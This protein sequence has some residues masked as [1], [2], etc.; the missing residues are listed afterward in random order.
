MMDGEQERDL[1]SARAWIAS[2]QDFF[3]ARRPVLIARAPGRLDVMGGIADYS[4]SLVL[5]LPLA[6]ATW[7]AVQTQERAELVIESAG[8][9]GGRVTLPLEEIVPAPPLSYAEARARLT[10]DPVA[11]WTAY[12]A[13]AL[14]VMQREYDRPLR[15]GARVL[16]RSD[17]PIGKGVGSSAA[18]EVAAFEALAALAGATLDD[19]ALALAAQRVENLIVGA[20]CGVMDQVTAACGRRGELTRIF[21]QPAHLMPPLDVPQGLELYGIDSGIRHAVSGSDYGSV[22]AAAFMGYRIVADAAGLTARVIAPGRVA[23]DDVP[24]FGGYLVNVWIG[25]WR[26]RYR[27][28]V[29]ERMTGREFLARF[30]GSTDTATT[31]EEDRTYPV[32]AAAEFPIL[33]ND[34]ARVFASRL[35]PS[36]SRGWVRET[37]GDLM[38]QSHAGYSACGLGSDGTDHLVELCRAAGPAAGIYGAKITG[39]GSGGTVAVLAKAGSRPAIEEIARA[40]RQESGRD[41]QIFAGSSSGSR[42]FGVRT[43]EPG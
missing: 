20:P 21:C 6:V 17:V 27:D 1:A 13:G 39:G 3:D 8:A 26:G 37:L 2:R 28:A 7:V 31:I 23:I 9:G 19:L 40:Y 5:E 36:A 22:R 4:G 43:L 12:V 18:L 35:E 11:A 41:A 33:E 29:P 38:Y 14:V 16:V 10:S 15:T 24:G 34:R 30:G 42:A 32:R 25:D